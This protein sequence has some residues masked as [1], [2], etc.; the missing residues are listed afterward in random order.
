[1]AV[2]P[3]PLLHLLLIAVSALLSAALIMLLKP[4]LA[5]Y[6]LARPGARSS[7]TIPT[8]QGGGVAIVAS[9]LAVVLAAM[10]AGIAGFRDP[11]AFGLVVALLVL[12]ATGALDDVRP[13]PVL[14]RLVL[15][16]AAAAALVLTLPGDMRALP[17]LPTPVERVLLIVGLV[18]F[19]NLT[20]F[21]DGIDWM[22]VVEAVPVL[23][24]IVVIGL[25][26]NSPAVS[27]TL[28]VTVTL[29]GAVL[30]FAPFNRH[31]ARLFL[32]D[33]GSLPIGAALGWLLILLSADGH[34]AAALILP[35]YYLADATS[36]LYRRWRRG[37][38]LSEAHRTHFYQLALG[39]GFSVPEV[40]TIVFRLNLILAALALA[41]VW[42]DSAPVG[43]L[44]LIAAAAVTAATLNRFERG[45]S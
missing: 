21:M 26:A 32:G 2:A 24:A 11:W 1:M 27:L 37:E 6:A 31:V 29:L 8:P 25:F 5:R 15:Q 36:T 22:T 33:V 23:T 34:L 45:R 9:V 40:T 39:R 43:V 17:W 18:W 35:L 4:L 14:P 12:A 3:H 10:A 42:L 28:P 7:H 41:T 16:F 30:G 13:L 20:N 38:R 19:I 44:A